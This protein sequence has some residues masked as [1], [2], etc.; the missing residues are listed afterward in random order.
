MTKFRR[1][2]IVD[3][4]VRGTLV[5]PTPM[6]AV[7]DLDHNGYMEDVAWFFSEDYAREYSEWRKSKLNPRPTND[8]NGGTNRGKL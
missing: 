5:A 7:V 6:F 3:C 4:L 8:A 1:N 2:K